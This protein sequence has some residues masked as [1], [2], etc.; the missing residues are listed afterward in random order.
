MKTRYDEMRDQF[1]AFHRA[2]PEVFDLFVRFTFELISTSRTHGAAKT[3]IERLR[4]ETSVVLQRGDDF[5]INNNHAPFYARLFLHRYPQHA[6][7]FR[8]REQ[9]SKSGNATRLSP[10]RPSDFQ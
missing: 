1:V 5:K 3:I 8:T 9:T 7:F 4:W 10:L 2:H 6:G